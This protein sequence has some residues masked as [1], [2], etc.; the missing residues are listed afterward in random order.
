MKENETEVYFNYLTKTDR[1]KLSKTHSNKI[2]GINK[3]IKFLLLVISHFREVQISGAKNAVLP[4]MAAAF[5]G[6]G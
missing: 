1:E 5:D 6:K 4:I 3:W 2:K